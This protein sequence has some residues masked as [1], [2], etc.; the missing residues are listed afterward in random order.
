MA[1]DFYYPLGRFLCWNILEPPL[2]SRYQGVASGLMRVT[3]HGTNCPDAPA[4][5]RCRQS[6]TVEALGW[7][8]FCLCLLTLIATCLWLQ[9]GKRNYV[10]DSL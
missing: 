3:R 6:L 4:I 7:T 5:S 10:S 1:A 9:T 2:T 8:E